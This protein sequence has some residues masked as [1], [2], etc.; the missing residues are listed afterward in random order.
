LAAHMFLSAAI[1]LMSS[2]AMKMANV[3]VTH[4]GFPVF[5]HIEWEIAKLL[6]AITLILP[7]IPIRVKEF[8]YHGFIILLVSALITHVVYGDQIIF[9]FMVLFFLVVLAISYKYYLEL[10]SKKEK[11]VKGI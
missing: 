7:F 5:F 10:S 4:W 9:I 6:G 2:E 8:A 3:Y 11:E 1:P